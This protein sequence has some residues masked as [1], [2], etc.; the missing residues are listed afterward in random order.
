MED[1]GSTVV[2]NPVVVIE[3]VVI[4]VVVVDVVV[5]DVVVDV[6]VV[7]SSTNTSFLIIAGDW[8][9]VLLF[10]TSYTYKS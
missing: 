1:E 7:C 4:D 8:L 10:S 2:I 9:N 6:V 5:V 3:V